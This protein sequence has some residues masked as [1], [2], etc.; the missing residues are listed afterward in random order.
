M[1]AK[2]VLAAL[3]FS[4][5]FFNGGT[6]VVS[7]PKARRS[8]QSAS[9]DRD[10]YL[11]GIGTKLGEA[12]ARDCSIF[13][14][15]VSS[16]KDSSIANTP[17]V[18]SSP[19][20]V[21]INFVVNEWLWNKPVDGASKVKLSNFPLSRSKPFDVSLSPDGKDIAPH[22]GDQF[23]IVSYPDKDNHLSVSQYAMVLS[24]GSV[25]QQVRDTVNRHALYL[26]Q[27]NEM[28][29]ALPGLDTSDDLVFCGYF[30]RYLWRAGRPNNSDNEAMVLGK[31]LINERIPSDGWPL[32][33]ATLT[34]ILF[35][36]DFP[37][38][39][40]SRKTVVDEIIAASSGKS[41]QLAK[42]TIPILLRLSDKKQL[43][44]KPFLSSD[45]LRNLTAN[46]RSLRS[47][48][49]VQDTHSEFEAQLHR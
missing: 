20:S 22:V 23:L 42:Q 33:R 41:I 46:Y 15:I 4:V 11:F 47:T 44:M 28:I 26:K 19:N 39:D 17:P 43:D 7:T 48:G 31:L 2:A 30:V 1:R 27:P 49:Y 36:A 3:L 25:F 40:T 29:N 18:K 34:R 12:L 10:R 9:S 24:D 14:G 5:V 16:V 38:S 21:E 13:V 45:R 35:D 37:I 6:R 32:I 8:Q